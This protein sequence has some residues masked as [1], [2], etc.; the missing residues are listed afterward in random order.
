MEYFIGIY[1][2]AFNAIRP[3]FRRGMNQF[4]GFDRITPVGSA[5][6]RN[7]QGLFMHTD[8]LH[9]FSEEV[10]FTCTIK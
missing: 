6:F 9:F 2:L 3:R 10:Y 1:Y 5:Q 8:T 7:N 4:R